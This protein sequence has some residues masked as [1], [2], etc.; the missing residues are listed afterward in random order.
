MF[1]TSYFVDYQHTDS[2]VDV[3]GKRPQR[4]N[5]ILRKN[6]VGK[7]T[8]SDDKTS[9]K[10]IVIKTVWYLQKSRPIY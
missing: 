1:P 4:V 10:A 6:K 7:L 8:L 9:Y 5:T 3:E 2:K